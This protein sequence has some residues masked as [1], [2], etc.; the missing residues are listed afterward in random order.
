MV[1]ARL[2]MTAAFLGLWLAGRPASA[3]GQEAPAG[4]DGW[5]EPELIYV[6]GPGQESVRAEL[7]ADAFGQLHVAVLVTAPDGGREANRLFYIRQ[8][9]GRWSEPIDVAAGVDLPAFEWDG[10]A[11][12]H[13][14]WRN[15]AHVA[16]SP[17]APL[18]AQE[19][20]PAAAYT[21]ARTGYPEINAGPDGQLHVLYPEQGGSIFYVRLDQDGHPSSP[22][23]VSATSPARGADWPKLAVDEAGRLHAVWTELEL[24]GGWP[25]L[26]VYYARSDDGGDSW[27]EPRPLA[28]EGYDEI[29]VATGPNGA[30]HVAWNGMAGVGGRFHRY[31]LDGGDNWS[32][33]VTIAELGFTDGWPQLV[34]DGRGVVHWLSW[35][36]GQ[37]SYSSWD[38]RA[39]SPLQAIA[40]SAGVPVGGERPRLA[41]SQG[42]QLHALLVGEG[43]WWY[44]RR[45]I[46][47]PATAAQPTPAPLPTATAAPAPSAAPTAT[48]GSRA[49]IQAGGLGGPPPP[50][51]LAS[52]G[53]VIWIGI[54]PA[55]LFILA[56]F[57]LARRPRRR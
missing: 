57:L 4:G 41:L 24:P 6:L 39:W 10:R 50:G 12:L 15:G 29:N 22:S 51:A 54:T 9:D 1:I 56:V 37:V 47:V 46:A 53:V 33:T 49:T 5:S 27:S 20:R 35:L 23:N 31:S 32:E 28:G 38:G 42:N 17:F 26:G 52:P 30:V 45:T 40:S 18:S 34:V 19:W 11:G 8:V 2:L 13:V 55:V 44:S 25:P 14:L 3:T 21:R 7:V 16:A 36:G 43:G 48:S